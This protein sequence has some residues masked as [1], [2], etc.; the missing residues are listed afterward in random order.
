MRWI[1]IRKT[2]CNVFREKSESGMGGKRM[3]KIALLAVVGAL[4]SVQLKSGKLD[5]NDFH[6]SDLLLFCP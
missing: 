5:R 1:G 2:E 6:A 4:L 3:I